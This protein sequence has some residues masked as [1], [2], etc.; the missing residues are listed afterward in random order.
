[1]AVVAASARF[2]TGR[3]GVSAYGAEDISRTL[4]GVSATGSVNTVEEKPTEVLNSVSSTGVVNTVTVNIQEDIT[5][6]SATGSIGT[7][8][9]SNTVTL[10][11]T[12]GT[13][14]IESVSAGGFEIDITERISTG[15]G[16]TGSI[17]TVAQ[18]KVTE[19]LAS[20]S[21]TGS[22]GTIIP[23]ANSKLTLT[24]VSATVSINEVEDQVT[25]KLSSVS[26]TGAVQ[27]LAQVKVSEALASAPATGTI[28]T[29]TTTAV[30]FDFQAVRE[31]YSRRRTI[32][33]AEAA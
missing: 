28:G 4:T 11:G 29:I 10:T 2:A 3:Y 7:L 15:V 22:I 23:H 26:A 33:I 21:S 25:E 31:Q 19:K 18:V 32:Y 6:V 9:I 17:N 13:T 24:S 12:A 20:A 5:G 1:M 8:S 30:V 14:A 16:S 27:A